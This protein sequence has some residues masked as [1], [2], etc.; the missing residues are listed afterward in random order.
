M[1]E[2]NEWKP[3]DENTPKDRSILVYAP[4]REGLNYLIMVCKWHDYAGFCVDEL[5][6]PTHW[7]ELPSIPNE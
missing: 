5:R 1:K 7:Q 2:L 6:C 4:S 3:I